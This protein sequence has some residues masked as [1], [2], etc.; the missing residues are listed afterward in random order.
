MK[1]CPQLCDHLIFCNLFAGCNF[2]FSLSEGYFTSPSY[3][4]NYPNSTTCNYTIN[5]Q[6]GVRQMTL[7]T[8]FMALEGSPGCLADSVSAY[9]GP[10]TSE[11]RIFSLCGIKR[12]MAISSKD[13]M[14]LQFKSDNQTSL[15]GFVAY[16]YI[17][18][19]FSVLPSWL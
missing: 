18:S 2:D 12:D 8:D 16:L 13:Q 6:K 5:K 17:P 11:F 10:S 14:F 19:K 7:W 4:L 3:P 9:D 15:Q 1:V